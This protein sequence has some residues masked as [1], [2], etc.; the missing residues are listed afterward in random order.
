MLENLSAL[1]TMGQETRSSRPI[2]SGH[3]AVRSRLK[4]HSG[5]IKQG[6]ATSNFHV[7]RDNHVDFRVVL[8]VSVV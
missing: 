6:T 1:S 8:L 3:R 2:G 4:S 5:G 7:Q